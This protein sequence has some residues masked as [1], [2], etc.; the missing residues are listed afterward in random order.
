MA[1]IE[2]HQSLSR[3]PKMKRAARTL[4]LSRPTMI[5]YLHL[6]WW[7]AVDYAPDG[8]IHPT[9]LDDLADEID[10]EHNPNDLI[11]ALAGAGL[12]VAVDG[13]WLIHDWDKHAGK[14]TAQSRDSASE[15]GRFGLHI[16]WHVNRG[17]V[18]ADCEHCP[19]IAPPNRGAN[20]GANS[21]D[22]QTDS[23]DN[24]SATPKPPP[25]RARQLPADWT[26]TDAHRELA[27]DEGVNITREATRFRNHAQANGRT[28]KDWNAAFRNWLLKAAEFSSANG[29]NPHARKGAFHG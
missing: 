16:R 13:G 29:T 23:T 2:S 22:R 21:T 26:P 27:R 14:A 15:Q 28:Q 3:H 4:K 8:L 5:G 1:W 18:A 6:L 11:D 12:L 24:A 9:D 10:W 7:W 17:I 20:R 19:P 25:A